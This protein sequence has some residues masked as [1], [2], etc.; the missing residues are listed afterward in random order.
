V[1]T[2][3]QL[4]KKQKKFGQNAGQIE[5]NKSSHDSLSLLAR[6]SVQSIPQFSQTAFQLGAKCSH[7]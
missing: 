3:Q 4:N 1:F 6:L 7:V 5:I 2:A